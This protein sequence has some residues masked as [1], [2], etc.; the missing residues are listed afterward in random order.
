MG[1]RISKCLRACDTVARLGGDEYIVL[2]P[3][4]HRI[5]EL[6]AIAEKIVSQFNECFLLNDHEIFIT[7]SIGIAIYPF[8]ESIDEPLISADTAMY[9]AKNKNGNNFQL[10]TNEM[11]VKNKSRIEME[12]SLR[13]ALLNDELVLYYQPKIELSTGKI[14]SFEALVRWE[15]SQKGLIPP[16]DFIPLAEET[17]LIVSIGEWVIKKHAIS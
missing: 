10:F 4:L 12:S 14:V 8:I 16:S 13:R 15:Y 3:Q 2:I 9:E 6:T 7:P 17:G 5:T 11:T 1:K